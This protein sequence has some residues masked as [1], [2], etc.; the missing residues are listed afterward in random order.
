MRIKEFG[1]CHNADYEEALTRGDVNAGYGDRGLIQSIE[2]GTEWV[3]HSPFEA[4]A[5]DGVYDHVVCLVNECS[6]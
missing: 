1:S 2:D 5:E 6:L 3:P 4:E